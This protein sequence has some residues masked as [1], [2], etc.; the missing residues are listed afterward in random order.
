MPLAP[1]DHVIVDDHAQQPPGF[2]DALGDLDI[3]AARLGR[4]GGVVVD[5][6]QP[7]GTQI[8][9]FIMTIRREF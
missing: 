7:A 2:G 5:Q 3:G 1:D 4:S 8:E 6:D 9:Q